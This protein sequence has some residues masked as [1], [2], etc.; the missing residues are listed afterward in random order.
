M[1][2]VTSEYIRQIL[3]RAALLASVAVG[4]LVYA[5]VQERWGL[6]TSFSDALHAASKLGMVAVA[7]LAASFGFV[8]AFVLAPWHDVE[9]E[10]S[11]PGRGPVARLLAE[12]SDEVHRR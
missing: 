10:A 5:V 4:M 11:V 7:V 3:I 8:F 12:A 2:R 1:S 9:P 6:S